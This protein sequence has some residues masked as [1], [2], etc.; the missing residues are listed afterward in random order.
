VQ[1]QDEGR[2]IP[3]EKLNPLQMQGAGVGIRGMGERVRQFNGKMNIKSDGNGTTVSFIFHVPATA[4][5]SP[6]IMGQQAQAA[7]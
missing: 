2:G 1:L 6:K 7:D 5:P 4:A 3:P